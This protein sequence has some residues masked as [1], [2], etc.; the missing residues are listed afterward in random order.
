MKKIRILHT[1]DL[2]ID[3]SF[4]TIENKTELLK[5]E[6][7]E[8]LARITDV[9]KAYKADIMVVCG[10]VTDNGTLSEAAYNTVY[11]CLQQLGIPVFMIMGNHDSGFNYKL[12]EN[13]HR[14]CGMQKYSIG[15]VDIYG[16]DFEYG[17]ENIS[18]DEN[19]IN[20]VLQHG[21]VGGNSDNPISLADIAATKADYFALGHIH[22]F[23]GAKK[24]GGTYYAYSGVPVGRGF[25][26]QGQKGVLIVDVEKNAVSAEFVPVAK[27]QYCEETVDISGCCDYV[28]VIEKLKSYDKDNLYKFRLK[29]NP[30]GYID[31]ASIKAVADREFFYAKIA[32]ET[33][34]EVDIKSLASEESLAGYFIKN[35]LL[36]GGDDETVKYG[37]A[38]LKGERIYINED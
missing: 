5:Y 30:S 2:H 22:S 9:A 14:F 21:T 7:L 36:N 25:D 38:A 3:T 11:K 34:V 10:D 32:D 29:G 18:V 13:V 31:F 33:T 19:K 37:L 6:L 17:F 27:R 12:P 28:E 15:N 16:S 1:A 24:S 35:V 4:F 8:S 26:E 20:I 23:D